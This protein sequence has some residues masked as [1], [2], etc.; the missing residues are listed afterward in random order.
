MNIEKKLRKLHKHF[1]EV[2]NNAAAE[3]IRDAAV[4]ANVDLDSGG[5]GNG[6]P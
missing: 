4:H 3:A 2:G 5:T 6:P 1:G